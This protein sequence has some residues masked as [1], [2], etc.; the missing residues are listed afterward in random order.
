LATDF[1]ANLQT[2]SNTDPTIVIP[3]PIVAD[4][5]A[6][7]A[8]W[9]QQASAV[10]QRRW[11]TLIEH[12]TF[13]YRGGDM[14]DSV[15]LTDGRVIW[16]GSDIFAGSIG[17][18]GTFGGVL[19]FRNVIFI[20]D[21]A[22]NFDSRVYESGSSGVAFSP[23]SGVYD[24]SWIYWAIACMRE[25]TTLH[26]GCWIVGPEGTYG[27]PRDSHIVSFDTS[28]F[29][30][31]SRIPMNLTLEKFFIDGFVTDGAYTYVYGE[32]FIPKYGPFTPGYGLPSNDPQGV[33]H[34]HVA[35]VPAGSVT[36]VGAYEFWAGG[37]WSP[38]EVD[39]MPMVDDNDD[40][41]EGD[42]GVYRVGSDSFMLAART[43]REENLRVYQST[44]PYGP[45]TQYATIATPSVSD[46]RYGGNAIGQLG[47]FVP[48]VATPAGTI[49]YSICPNILGATDPIGSMAYISF[50]TRFVTVPLPS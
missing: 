38:D 16:V 21:A 50:R 45:W 6:R 1:T 40:V 22:G 24:P 12:P 44:T 5:A 13:N 17:S 41:I 33:T 11:T 29:S 20:Q 42:A 31:I 47:K 28:N 18:D 9:D 35:R 49:Q 36:N 23:D 8:A 43:L 10:E 27:Y 26:I 7:D 3:A 32:E 39:M 4:A 30:L 14:T 37:G 25:G 15:E 19:P 34:K 2:M 46:Q 48:H